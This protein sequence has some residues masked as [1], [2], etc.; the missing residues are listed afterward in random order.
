MIT[1]L[2]VDD[3]EDILFLLKITL[4][5]SGYSV[6]TATTKAAFLAWLESADPDLIILDVMLGEDNGRDICQEIKLTNRKHIPIMLYSAVASN[7][8]DYK[9]CEANDILEKPFELEVL[10]EKVRRL[11]G[12][13]S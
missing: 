2:V 5:K 12:K 3:A 7:L 10:L 8:A 11:T 6:R 1:I 4:E 9:A 13:A